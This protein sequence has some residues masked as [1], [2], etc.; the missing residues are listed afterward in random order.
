MSSPTLSPLHSLSALG[1][2]VWIDF[3]SREA[4]RGGHLQQLIDRDAVVGA[5]SNPS[6][7]QKAMGSGDAYDEHQ[8]HQAVALFREVALADQYDEFLTL[9]AYERMP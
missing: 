9:P 5:T 2:S 8:Y 6:I 7:F 1:Q 4:I 3:L